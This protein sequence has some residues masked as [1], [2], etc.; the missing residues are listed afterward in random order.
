[1]E[2]KAKLNYL[3]ISP[4]KVRLVADLIRG[5][6]VKQA[7]VELSHLVKRSAKPMLKLLKSAEANAKNNFGLDPDGLYIKSL[8]VDEGPVLKRW[9]ARAFGRAAMIRKRTSHV[10][11]VLGVR[12]ESVLQE[13]KI[14]KD[15]PLVR[16]LTEEDLKGR[17]HETEEQNLTP[18]RLE[19]SKSKSF[20][21]SDFVKR[22]FRRKAI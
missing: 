8:R 22:V 18:S 6:E 20:K 19:N 17:L 10:R 4:R 14:Q 2:V 15:K 1:M 12:G 11:M 9:R 5:M 3:R 16:E 21:S 7:E 13:K